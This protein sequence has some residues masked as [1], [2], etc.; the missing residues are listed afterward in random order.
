MD[1]YVSEEYWK[2]ILLYSWFFFSP[3]V[4]KNFLDKHVIFILR[5]KIIE[6]HY[7]KKYLYWWEKIEKVTLQSY[8]WETRKP[9]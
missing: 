6:K 8:C 3:S 1:N 4:F 9:Q 2:V 5:K 7:L